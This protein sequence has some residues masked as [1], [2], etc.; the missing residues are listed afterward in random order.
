M[1]PGWWRVL[2]LIP[3]NCFIQRFHRF[4]LLLLLVLNSGH[5]VI[6]DRTTLRLSLRYNLAV[7]A[8]HEFWSPPQLRVVIDEFTLKQDFIDQVSVSWPLKSETSS[9]GLLFWFVK[10]FITRHIGLLLTS[11]D[12]WIISNSYR[13]PGRHFFQF[14]FFKLN[15]CIQ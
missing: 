10:I 2:S 4:C 1:T 9:L 8:W 14:Y 7:L 5:I 11:N 6:L 15:S 13:E 3:G 12:W